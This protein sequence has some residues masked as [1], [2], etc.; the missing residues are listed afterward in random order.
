MTA[1]ASPDTPRP[2]VSVLLLLTAGILLD[3]APAA[4]ARQSGPTFTRD[5]APILQRSCQRCHRPGSIAP[6]ALMTYEEVR[7]WAA[8]IRRETARRAMPPWF[9]DK[10]VGIQHYRDDPSLTD[11]EIALLGTWAET[12]APE[13]DEA[14]LPPAPSFPGGVGWTIGEPDLIVESPAVTVDANAPDWWGAIGAVPTG[15]T[16]DRYIAAVET[17]EISDTTG[18]AVFH[19]A[20]LQALTPDGRFE[21]GTIHEVGRNAELFDPDAAPPLTAGSTIVF[22]NAHLHATGSKTTA[23]LRVGFRFLPIGH[24]PRF[25]TTGITLGN[26]ELD[27]RGNTPDQMVEAF[28]TLQQPIKLVSLEPHMHAAGSRMCLEAVWG[29]V[30]QTLTCLG[31]DPEWV[32]AYAYEPDAA[33]LLPRGTLL[34]L[35]GWMD[36]TPNPGNPYLTDYR[37]WTGWGSR[38]VDNMFMSYLKVILLTGDQFR[39]L[40]T[41]R[42]AK[43]RAGTASTLGCLPCTLPFAREAGGSR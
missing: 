43:A 2:P 8:A 31:F 14:D 13:G 19:H 25:E 42:T 24:R 10:A 12:G 36:T 4:R 22:N 32:R 23:H 26:P 38:P 15:L 7:P 34:R 18:G 21:M 37:N 16:E 20:G 39:E 30:R 11:A 33:P 3:P 41:D 29:V 5:V 40:V 27:V 17:I 9:I 1:P 6:M 35:V 28:T